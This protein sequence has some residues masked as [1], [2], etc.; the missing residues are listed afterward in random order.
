MP[1]LRR[2]RPPQAIVAARR[3]SPHLP[4]LHYCTQGNRSLS[5]RDRLRWET[6]V[7]GDAALSQSAS[8]SRQCFSSVS[9][10]T[11]TF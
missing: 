1:T 10:A 6:E 9:I 3:L 11:V 8:S 5:M 2:A 7:P 4:G